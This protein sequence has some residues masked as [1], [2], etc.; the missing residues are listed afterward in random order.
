M[1]S[2]SLTSDYN[3]GCDTGAGGV[4]MDAYVIELP[5]IAASGLTE[6]SGTITAITKVTGKIF[7][8][9]QLVKETASFDETIAGNQ[10]NGTIFYDQ[11]G[12]I[13]INKQN[14]AVRNELKYMSMQRLIWIV[15]DNNGLWKLY[16]REE[17]L[18]L[19]DGSITTGTAWTDRNGYTLNFTGKEREPAPFVDE[20]LITALQTAT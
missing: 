20:A 9:Y 10:Q 14:V 8:K 18:K 7:R 2:C 15:R 6:S 5:N 17:G 12:V 19:L 4:Y 1:A 13:I 3:F 11:K 16:G